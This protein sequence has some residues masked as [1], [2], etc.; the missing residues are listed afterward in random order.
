MSRPVR[1]LPCDHGR[2]GLG[3]RWRVAT[4]L[5]AAAAGLVLPNAGVAAGPPL[6]LDGLTFVASR[7]S[8]AEVRVAAR[9]A[10]IDEASNK[11]ELT[12]VDAEWAGEDG[13]RSLLVTCDR[14][15]LDLETNDLLASGAVHGEF[16]DGRR[17][18]SPWLRY[19]RARGV[20][21]TDAPVQILEGGRVLRG[22]GLE[23]HV[24]ERRLRLTA[25]AK[26]EEKRTQ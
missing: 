3:P 13:K 18:T 17:F 4:R 22:G 6:A 21:Y 24:R 20:A 2:G 14:G 26:V 7:E 12:S 5:V 9:A 8:T 15:E 23:Y 16:A 19:D 1:T 11:A 25:G 10:V